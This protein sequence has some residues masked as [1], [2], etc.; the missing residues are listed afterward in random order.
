[1][2]RRSGGVSRGGG[3]L[4]SGEQRSSAAP[5]SVIPTRR[6]ICDGF[7]GSIQRPGQRTKQI[8]A[9]PHKRT[10]AYRQAEPK[11]HFAPVE[12]ASALARIG[13]DGL[14][15]IG[16]NSG[17]AFRDASRATRRG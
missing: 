15:R 5:I 3:R 10:F 1:M 13:G 8:S 11:A 6:L 17:T 4:H 7:S 14:E 12:E 9:L 16:F 2:K